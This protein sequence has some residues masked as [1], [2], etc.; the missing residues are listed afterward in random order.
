MH[1]TVAVFAVFSLMG[2]DASAQEISKTEH[3]SEGY[4]AECDARLEGPI[5]SGATER[6]RELMI[7]EKWS[8][9]GSAPTICLNSPGGSL[10]EAIKMQEYFLNE[11]IFTYVSEGD[12]CLSACA[13][14]LLAGSATFG[15]GIMFHQFSRRIHPNSTIGFHAPSLSVPNATFSKSQI[16]NA[17]KTGTS[18][19]RSFMEMTHRRVRSQKV[20]ENGI[21]WAVLLTPPEDIFYIDTVFKS[22]AASISLGPVSIDDDSW[23]ESIPWAASSAEFACDNYV[24]KYFFDAEILEEE[25]YLTTLKGNDANRNDDFSMLEPGEISYGKLAKF[26]FPEEGLVE[27]Y[28][29]YSP[30]SGPELYYCGSYFDGQRNSWSVSLFRSDVRYGPSGASLLQEG[31]VWAWVGLPMFFPLELVIAN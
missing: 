13:I 22:Y 23:Y 8:P 12:E 15:N 10:A 18:A 25:R 4:F 16:E 28:G 2:S 26:L 5:S 29:P 17:F 11:N 27:F 14:V 31:R 30:N 21:L 6:L 1:L 3:F 24:N 9:A 20:M 19:L 7:G